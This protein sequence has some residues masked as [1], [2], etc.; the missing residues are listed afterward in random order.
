MER[1]KN[2]AARDVALYGLLIALAF[3][4]SYVESLIPISLGVP[5]VKLGLAN[6][7]VIAALYTVGAGGAAFISLVRIVLMGFTFGTPSMILYSLAGGILSLLVMA[8]LKRFKVFGMVGTSVAGGAQHRPDRGGGRGGGAGGSVR[9]PAGAAGRGDRCG[10]PDR[11]FG[12]DGGPTDQAGH[13][14]VKCVEFC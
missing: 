4:L 7:A 6:L 5:G 8:F 1:R 14:Q 13:N 11:P 10:Q 12:R 2:M 9:L 3:V